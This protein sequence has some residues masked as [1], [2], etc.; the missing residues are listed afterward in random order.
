MTIKELNYKESIAVI[1]QA[2]KESFPQ[3]QTGRVDM[4]KGDIIP[5]PVLSDIPILGTGFSGQTIEWLAENTDGWI[6]YAQEANRQQE[7]IKLWRD[8]AGKFKPFAQPLALTY[9]RILLTPS[10]IKVGFRSGHKFLIDYL[11][12]LQDIGV[13]HVIFGLKYGHQ[14]CSRSDSRNRRIC[15]TTFSKQINE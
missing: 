14:A 12:A 9:P 2:W 7:L 15:T 6:F 3:I 10:P 5:K 13:N 11:H 1:R 4:T 8:A